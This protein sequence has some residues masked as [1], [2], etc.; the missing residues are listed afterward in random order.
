MLF[1]KY[2]F[3]LILFKPIFG[4][5]FIGSVLG[6][7]ANERSNSSARAESRTN[8]EFQEYMTNNR[9]QIEVEDLRKAG[10]NPILSATGG[11]P[12]PSGSQASI[13]RA[14]LGEPASAFMDQVLKR[15]QSKLFSEQQT[16]VS[17]Q[18]GKTINE[19]ANARNQALISENE[20][21]RS[22]LALRK[23]LKSPNLHSS[24]RAWRDA[25]GQSPVSSAMQV[26]NPLMALPFASKVSKFFPRG[27]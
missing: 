24:A 19:A 16:L 6:F 18:T 22:D 23:W 15:Q 4:L 3:W 27:K 14:E 8:R 7:L 1:N 26:A 17:A 13:T 25:T 12:V 20:A 2:N 21:V 11:A 5:S 10:L 9:H